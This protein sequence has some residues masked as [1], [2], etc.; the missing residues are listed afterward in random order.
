MQLADDAAGRVTIFSIEEAVF[1]SPAP[2]APPASE[3]AER[4]LTLRNRVGDVL[5]SPQA[6]IILAVALVVTLVLG[7][8]LSRH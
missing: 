4:S 3:P 8:L 1:T 7:L 6:P 5:D 2:G